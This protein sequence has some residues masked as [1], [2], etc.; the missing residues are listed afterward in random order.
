M[1]DLKESKNENAFIAVVSSIAQYIERAD[2][3]NLQ[4]GNKSAVITRKDDEENGS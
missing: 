4:N 2:T 3:L 1:S